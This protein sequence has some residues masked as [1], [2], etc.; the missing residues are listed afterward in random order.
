MTNLT[1]GMTP[2]EKARVRRLAPK[3]TIPEIAAK[4]GVAQQRIYRFCRLEGV[5]IKPVRKLPTDTD[6]IRKALVRLESVEAVAN[7]YGV[8]RQAIYYRLKED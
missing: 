4:M 6:E 8:T 2:Q 5:P 1:A 3:F 7:H